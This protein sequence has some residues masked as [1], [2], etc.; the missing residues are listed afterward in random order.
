MDMSRDVLDNVV[1]KLDVELL[2]LSG[3]PGIKIEDLKVFHSKFWI[4]Q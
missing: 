4:L 2:K 1:D 3:G